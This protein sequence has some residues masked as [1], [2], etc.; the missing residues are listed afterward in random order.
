MAETKTKYYKGLDGLRAFSAVGIVMMHVL[1]NGN[2]NLGGFVFEILIPSFTNL[3]FLFMIISGFSVCC[4]YYDKI[5][6]NRISI[7]DFYR[8]R[9]AKIWPYFSVL[10]IIDLIISPSKETIYEVFANMTLCFGLLP[11]ANITVIGV[12]WF[13]GVVFVF[14]LLFPFFCYLLADNKRAWIVFLLAGIFNKLCRDYFFNADHVLA[15]F[16]ARTNIVYCAVFFM[17]GGLIFLYKD[18]I[19]KIVEK[20]NIAVLLAAIA[21][22]ISYYTL[23]VSELTMLIMFSTFLIFALRNCER[24]ILQNPIVKFVS[25]IS[26][27]I[28]L[29]HMVIYRVIEKVGL[30]HLFKADILSYVMAT[31]TTFIGAI[32]F[33]IVLNYCIN[34]ITKKITIGEMYAD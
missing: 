2:Y 14:Y 13:L 11:N 12:G 27:E 33:S 9:Y 23:G 24:G 25:N 15:N 30:V 8:K 22:T 29:S 28:Y 31:V 18:G 21:I 6:N 5:L 10:C 16:Y 7:V 26:M 20:Y 1:A 4:G 17:A 34:E 3:V 19:E 32:V